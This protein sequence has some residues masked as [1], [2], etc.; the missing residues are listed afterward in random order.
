MLNTRLMLSPCAIHSCFFL[1][2]FHHN[3]DNRNLNYAITVQILHSILMMK[4]HIVIHI[5]WSIML[6]WFCYNSQHFFLNTLRQRQNSCHFADN[7]FKSILLNENI[8]ISIDISLNFVPK[9]Q[10]NNMPILGQIMACCI[11]SD[12]CLVSTRW[13]AI[14]YTNDGQFTDTYMHHSASMS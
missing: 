7:I 2:F 11:G 6:L 12:K 9:G 13:Q 4:Y 8:W 3:F 10:I 1:T 5:R 14:I